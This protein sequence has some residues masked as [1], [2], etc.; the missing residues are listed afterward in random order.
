M[1][2]QGESKSDPLFDIS[3]QVAV[4]TGAYGL[5]GTQLTSAFIAR[6]AQLA[7]VDIPG[8]RPVESG[9]ATVPGTLCLACD[10]AK[11]D[12]VAEIVRQVLAHFGRVDILINAHTFRPRGWAEAKAECFP[13]SFGMA[14]WTSI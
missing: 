2:P 4:I 14:S 10:V 11:A 1:K 5:V 6:G 7:L 8:S 13:K 3:G 9:K 12:Q